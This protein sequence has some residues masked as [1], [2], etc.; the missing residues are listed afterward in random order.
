[1]NNYEK[2]VHEMATKMQKAS[3]LIVND[4]NFETTFIPAARILVKETMK[5]V[6]A[7]LYEIE[8]DDAIIDKW[9]IER[10]LIPPTGVG[11]EA[12]NNESNC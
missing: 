7:I 5:E 9:L 12:G 6:R 3:P 11:K 1:M 4:H 2:R 10:G 8:S